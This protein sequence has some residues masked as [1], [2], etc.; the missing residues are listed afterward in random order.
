TAWSR[1]N[2]ATRRMFGENSNTR[3]A[4]VIDG[5]SN[6]IAVAE[7]LYDVYNGE[8]AGWGYRGWVQVGVD[9]GYNGINIWE[10]AWTIIHH[11]TRFGQLGTWASAGS[12]HPGGCHV[13]MGDG[14]AH[15]ISD[16]TDIFLLEDLSTMAGG[17]VVTNPE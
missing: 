16:T 8:C 14:S 4:N 5:T 2:Q 17:E 10:S 9:V 1:E 11:T 13:L 3:V 12:M 15:F 7:T 6:T